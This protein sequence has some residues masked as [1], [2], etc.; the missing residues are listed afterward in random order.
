MSAAAHH[1]ATTLAAADPAWGVD[2]TAS[3]RTL[4]VG[5]D[6]LSLS[7]TSARDGYLSVFYLGSDGVSLAQ[8]YPGATGDPAYLRAGTPFAIPRQWRSQ[9]PPGV[10]HILAVVADRIVSIPDLAQIQAQSFGAALEN[11]EEVREH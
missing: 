10:N 3:S 5:R 11:V 1:I 9:G 8:L 2:I 7:V 6:V 4:H